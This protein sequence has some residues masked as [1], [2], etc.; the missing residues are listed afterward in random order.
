MIERVNYSSTKKL[1]EILSEGDIN[2]IINQVFESAQ[3]WNVKGREG[4]A[5]FFR[6][7]DACLIATIY[8]L[9][10]RPKEGCCLRFDDFNFR[11]MTIKIRGVNNKVKKDRILPMPRALNNV[12]RPYLAFPRH[13]FWKGSKYLFPSY[14]NAH[15]SPGSLKRI[16][17]EKVLKPLG[18]WYMP[19]NC[20]IPKIRCYTLR[21]SRASHILKKQIMETGS[22]DIFAISNFLGHGDIR[23]TTV[24]LHTDEKYQDYLRSQIE[25]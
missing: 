21:H 16:M 8:I 13:R 15:I 24:Y 25:I 17:R 6:M 23:S 1:P 9:G 22:P 11:N 20:R 18:L 10:L 2:K 5:R 7:R 4:W 12:L 19:E 14:M 3:Y